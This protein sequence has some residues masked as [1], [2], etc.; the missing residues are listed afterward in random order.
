ML[1]LI[2]LG[3][4]ITALLVALGEEAEAAPPEEYIPT[5]EQILASNSWAE[6]QAYYALIG[7][8]YVSQ[9]ID[10]DTY[11]SL[12]NAYETRWRQLMEGE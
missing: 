6:L 2:A 12:Y 9:V 8:L 5:P 7:E 3:V 1:G 4:S 10:R 11:I